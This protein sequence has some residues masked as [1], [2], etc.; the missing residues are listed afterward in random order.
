M[1]ITLDEMDF[2]QGGVAGELFR[3]VKERG[4]G[5]FRVTKAC[6]EY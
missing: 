3:I 6:K 2:D 5:V 4:L 1:H